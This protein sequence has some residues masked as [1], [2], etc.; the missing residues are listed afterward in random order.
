LDSLIF[1]KFLKLSD[2]LQ[3]EVQCLLHGLSIAK[4]RDID[5][6]HLP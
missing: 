2:L 4:F 5:D 1:V 3:L 6:F